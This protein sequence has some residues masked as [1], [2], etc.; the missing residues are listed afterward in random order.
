MGDGGGA[1]SAAMAATAA[2]AVKAVATVDG[3]AGPAASDDDND[4]GGGAWPQVHPPG[5]QLQLGSP[6]PGG[7][8]RRNDTAAAA[9]RKSVV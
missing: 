7:P 5:P 1:G 3:V 8:G 2:A 9:D 6:S 4:R